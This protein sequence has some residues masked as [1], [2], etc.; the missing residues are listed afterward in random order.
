VRKGGLEAI[1]EDMKNG[2][3]L[4][5]LGP[6]QPHPTAGCV[7]VG[8]RDFLIAF[9]VN[10]ASSNLEIAKKIASS[11]REKGG[12]LIGVKA[13]GINLAS[14]GM[15]Q[16]SMNITMPF[17]TPLYRVYELVKIEAKRYGVEIDSGEIIGPVP[18]QVLIDTLSYYLPLKD[19]KLQQVIDIHI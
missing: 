10:L 1:R 4:P 13:L 5:D 19:F 15:V 7:I 8:V 9:N 18:L 6:L 2:R 14:R 16:V 11:V 12:G 17:K 3:R